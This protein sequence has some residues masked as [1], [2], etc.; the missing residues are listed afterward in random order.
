MCS[1][2]RGCGGNWDRPLRNGTAEDS[3]KVQFAS[4]NEPFIIVSLCL[5]GGRKLQVALQSL[6]KL[7]GRI[8]SDERPFNTPMELHLSAVYGVHGISCRQLVVLAA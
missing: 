6:G 5:S 8:S 2:G 7:G 3:L 1:I 4:D